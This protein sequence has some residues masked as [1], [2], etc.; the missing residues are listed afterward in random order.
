[1]CFGASSASCL[2]RLVVLHSTTHS[3]Y[4]KY[5]TY[6]PIMGLWLTSFVG[7]RS[8][9][10][11]VSATD[12]S[13]CGHVDKHPPSAGLRSRV[14]ASSSRPSRPSRPP[15][16]PGSC[17]LAV[18]P[19]SNTAGGA[20]DH[21]TLPHRVPVRARSGLF[22]SFSVWDLIHPA[23]IVCCPLVS[24][25]PPVFAKAILCPNAGTSRFSSA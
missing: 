22:S 12:Y 7:R 3:L 16:G 25:C 1:M 19:G 14:M 13:P 23:C 8:L 18:P 5:Y 15:S 6:L 2:G 11:I 9:A 10:F 21:V 17:R 20:K 24:S 4:R